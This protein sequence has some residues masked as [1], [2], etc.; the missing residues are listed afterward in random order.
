M[1]ITQ[2]TILNWFNIQAPSDQR[3]SEY[4][5]LY[6]LGTL[7]NYFSI[8]ELRQNYESSSAFSLDTLRLIITGYWEKVRDTG[9][10]L[11]EIDDLLVLIVL[12]H[13]II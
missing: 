8:D 1:E 11:S 4:N 5:D 12:I 2:E 9:L 13:R 3:I 6:K 10:G 7:E